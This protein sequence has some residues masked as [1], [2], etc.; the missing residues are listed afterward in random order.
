MKKTILLLSFALLTGCNNNSQFRENKQLG[1]GDKILYEG[2]ISD[3]KT[4]NRAA[5]DKL[6]QFE[7][8]YPKSSNLPEVMIL[9]IY[10][11]YKDQDYHAAVR[12][13]EK[14]ISLYPRHQ[15]TAYAYYIK[16]M[17]S[18][19]QIMDSQRDQTITEEA[20]LAFNE[21]ERQFPDSSYAKSAKE[22]VNDAKNILAVKQIEIGRSYSAKGEYG[23]AAD[24]YQFVLE[25]YPNTLVEP[26]AIYRMI[27]VHI[28][29]NSQDYAE[30]YL[31]RL[32][33]SYPN[34][35]WTNKAMQLIGHTNQG[36]DKRASPLKNTN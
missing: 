29:L 12:Q 4:N 3:I 21:L 22:I 28:N 33:R 31:N 27:E 25:K 18:K 9:K 35:T 36:S 10:A 15:D 19:I 14:F 6:S 7:L 34:S 17:C 1:D 8:K 32:K 26:E 11:L 2:A 5:I 20:L 23:A 13:A 16:G 24:R 30:K